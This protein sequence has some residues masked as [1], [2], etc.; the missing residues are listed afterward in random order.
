MEVVLWVLLIQ[1]SLK[2]WKEELVIAFEFAV[3]I[4]VLLH[5]I[6]GKV[7]IPIQVL[8]CK[9]PT[10]S[11]DVPVL[12]PVGLNLALDTGQQHVAPDV[13]LPFVI[14]ERLG[15]VLLNYVKV[16]ILM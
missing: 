16:E 13:E 6:V 5:C 15:D 14:Q 4:R 12:I 7:D 3:V 10:W 8:Y 9:L 11:P 1:I 2:L